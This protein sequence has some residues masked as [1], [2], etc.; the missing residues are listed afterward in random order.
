MQIPGLG[1]GDGGAGGE[2]ITHRRFGKKRR[3]VLENLGIR[4]LAYLRGN[5]E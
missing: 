4:Y 5:M 2:S 1:A 3:S